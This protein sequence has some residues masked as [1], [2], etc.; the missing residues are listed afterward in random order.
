MRFLIIKRSFAIFSVLTLLTVCCFA[1]EEPPANRISMETA[2]ATAVKAYPGKVKGEELEFENGK[3]I[4]SFDLR[5][6]KDKSEHEINVDAISGKVLN[7]HVET[8]DEEKKELLEDHPLEASMLITLPGKVGHFDFMEVDLINE[9]LLAAHSGGESLTVLDLKD[10]KLISSIDVGEVQGVAVDNRSGTYILG[11]A[12]GHKIVF[13]SSTSLK[14]TG[15][16]VVTGP[17]DAVAFDS[18]NGMAYAGEDD[19]SHIWVIDVKN[20]KLVKTLKISGVPE[21]VVYDHETDRIYQNIK[22]KNLVAVI[23]PTTNKVETEWSTLPATGPH[24]LAVDSEAGRIFVAGHNGKLVGIDLKSGKVF[25]EAEI[26]EGTDQISF[27]ATSKTI[28]AASKGFISVVKETESGLQ[29]L[30]NTPAHRGAHTLAVDPRR[31]EVWVS[32]ADKK[33][34]FLQKFIQAHK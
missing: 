3:W 24:G 6:P 21:F 16:L 28:Y 9:R 14:K 15:E 5:K 27:D 34:S 11:D 12:D 22:T 13:V 25:A 31:H 17:V 2:R 33:H 4:Y 10:D 1:K 18:K 32:Y 8:P 26:K 23:N 20:K 29:S 19:G 7:A 30:G